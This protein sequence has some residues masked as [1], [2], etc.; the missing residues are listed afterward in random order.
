[1]YTL[2]TLH[3]SVSSRHIGGTPKSWTPIPTTVEDM[4]FSTIAPPA[5][6]LTLPRNAPLAFHVLI[7]P[8]GA[9]CNLDCKYCFFLS[10]EMLY[11]GSRFQMADDLLETYLKQLLESHQAPEVD[12]AWQGGEPTLKG[13]CFADEI[14]QMSAGEKAALARGEV[15]D[16]QYAQL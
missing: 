3:D 9:I 15:N 10:K 13:G 1:M 4:T 2:R 8:T 12:V 11:P 6:G 7:K 5:G 16:S 14:M